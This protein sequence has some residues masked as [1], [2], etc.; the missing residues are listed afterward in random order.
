MTCVGDY[1]IKHPIYKKF[2]E[3]EIYTCTNGMLE[4][5]L[6]YLYQAVQFNVNYSF[7]TYPKY[8]S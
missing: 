8:K 6:M 4:N 2:I 7:T 3:K 5:G 1:Q